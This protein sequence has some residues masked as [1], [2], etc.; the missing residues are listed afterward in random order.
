MASSVAAIATPIQPGNIQATILK[1]SK[2][3]SSISNWGR[4]LHST[5]DLVDDIL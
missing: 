5:S 4:Q 2:G 1:G 3:Q